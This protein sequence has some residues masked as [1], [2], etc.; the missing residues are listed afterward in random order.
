MKGDRAVIACTDKDGSEKEENI[1][2]MCTKPKFCVC[3]TTC[4]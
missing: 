3:A 2:E 1:R 4:N